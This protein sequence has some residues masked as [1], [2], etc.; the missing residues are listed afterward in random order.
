[1]HTNQDRPR[2]GRPP[3]PPSRKMGPVH[4]VRLD[5]DGEQLLARC[6][7]ALGADDDATV[8]RAALVALAGELECLPG[9][10]LDR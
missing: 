8:L 9:D 3:L 7:R 5:Q 2:I 1:M 6:K 4:G 10:E